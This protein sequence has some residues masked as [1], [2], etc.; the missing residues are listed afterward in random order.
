VNVIH[1]PLCQYLQCYFFMG[2]NDS[3][4]LLKSNSQ[5]LAEVFRYLS[6]NLLIGSCQDDQAN[7]S[8]SLLHWKS[9][10]L[11]IHLKNFQYNLN[12]C[13]FRWKIYFQIKYYLES[14]HYYFKYFF[15]PFKNYL[16]I[17]WSYVGNYRQSLVGYPEVKNSFIFLNSVIHLNPNW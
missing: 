8:F 12:I 6:G 7:N 15:P 16:K 1:S 2:K 5:D 17:W 13:A 4:L 14:Y 11:F 9:N 3:C 10:W